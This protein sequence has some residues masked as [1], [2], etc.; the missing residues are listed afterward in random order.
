MVANGHISRPKNEWGAESASP[1]SQPRRE[2]EERMGLAL[3]CAV[4]S[5][6]DSTGRHGVG[7]IQSKLISPLSYILPHCPEV[8]P[9]RGKN[10]VRNWKS[11]VVGR[12]VVRFTT[13][14][15]A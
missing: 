5:P 15:V 14:I 4:Y 1:G 6:L 11:K 10:A 3:G 12:P 13:K 7:L 2:R 8:I 9:R